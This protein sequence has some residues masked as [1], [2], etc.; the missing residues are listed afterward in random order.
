VHRNRK[1]LNPNANQSINQYPE[2]NEGA[3]EYSACV[4]V[5]KM[6]EERRCKN[7]RRFE[8]R[9]HNRCC[10]GKGKY[11]KHSECVSVVLAIQH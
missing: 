8:A 7:K 5:R 11:I 9:S 3:S 4:G 6:K 10:N 2:F 1:G